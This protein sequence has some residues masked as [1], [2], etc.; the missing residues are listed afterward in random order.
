[1]KKVTNEIFEETQRESIIN[2]PH[3]LF[4]SVKKI[5]KDRFCVSENSIE[6]KES[7]SVPA[8]LKIFME[9]IDNPIDL[10]IKGQCKK[11]DIQVSSTSI[12]VKD[13]GPGVNSAVDKDGEYIVFKAFCKYN[14]SS[15]YK[16]FKNQ[17]QKGVNGIGIKGSNTL[18][19]SFKVVSDDGI[20]KITLESTDNNLNHKIK[21]SNT[22]GK[23]GVYITFEPDFKIFDIDNIDNEH[24][25]RMYEYTLM[26]ALSYPNATFTFNGKQLK[27]P[28]KKFVALLNPNHIIEEHDDYFLAI[29]PNEFDDHKQMS[30][31]N[32]LETSKGGT[33]VNYIIDNIV[34]K[35]REKLI[36][37]YKTIKPG[38]I[39]NKLT[40]V[41]IAKD[42][43]D[44]DWDG[45]TKESITTPNK[46]WSEYF[47]SIDFE[48]LTQKII[49][50]AAIIDPITETFKLKEELKLRLE[51]KNSEKP[52]KN[53][54]KDEKLLTPI[55]KWENIFLC[56]G[57]SAQNSISKIIGRQGNG[58]Y[59]MFG[60]PPNAYDMKMT[61]ILKSDKMKGLQSVLGLKYSQDI[62]DSIT[63][64]NII[65][66]T[67]AD[68]PGFFIRMQLLGLF[69]RFGKNLFEEGRIKILRTP[70]VIGYDNKENIKVWFYD[71]DDLKEYEQSDKPKYKFEYKKG[72][73]SWDQSELE[74]IITQDG[75]NT[76]LETMVLDKDAP[77]SIHNWLSGSMADKRKDMLDGYEF[78]IANM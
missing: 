17:G 64:D 7:E 50:V 69:Y 77:E 14:T 28:P 12:S 48:K 45:Q 67:D 61:D 15:N 18:S 2:R 40:L 23:T 36:K 71:L 21:E 73:G 76:M 44:I 53:K 54:P 24:I 62:Q 65:I 75:L 31:V 60:V 8:L 33:H 4:G 1:M 57:D 63:F 29:L 9:A 25:N 34:A 46:Y 35:I 58:F 13:D 59:A 72:L 37:K 39:K 41:L 5:S 32:G 43:R 66:A 47:N 19:T 52:E 27:Y 16:E 42:V 10:V 11:I 70:V 6:F 78:S 22:T 55:G 30:Y 26:Q 56:E 20:K 51:L 49:K 68:L 3:N 38:D 74:F